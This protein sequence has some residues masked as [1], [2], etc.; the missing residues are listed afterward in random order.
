MMIFILVRHQVADY[1][2]WQAEFQA[3]ASRRMN[4]G[5]QS[6][7]VFRDADDP[8]MI[9]IIEEWPDFPTAQMFIQSEDLRRRMQAGGVI[10]DPT[11]MFLQEA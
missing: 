11:I 5:E 2:R 8:K 1:D 4:S 10:G 6:V 3:D 7:R 9:T